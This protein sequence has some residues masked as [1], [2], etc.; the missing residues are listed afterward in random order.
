MWNQGPAGIQNAANSIHLAMESWREIPGYE[1]QYEA[2]N[3]GRVKSLPNTA[4][5][6]TIILSP[7]RHHKGG[8]LMV[9]LHKAGR[10]KNHFVHRLVLASH[11]GPCPAGMEGCHNDG[12]P[13]NNALANLRW[14]TSA[15]N[16]ADRRRHGRR[17]APRGESH[18]CARL[19]DEQ[20]RAIRDEP[21]VRGSGVAL[22]RRF[23]VTPNT[24]YRIRSGRRR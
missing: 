24:V 17:L 19:T 9:N 6:A 13:E 2:S 1:G 23:G 4:H 20:V 12:D 11:V 10:S 22:A 5:K 18:P 7:I 15:A 3:I 21:S 14:D 16:N 8:Y